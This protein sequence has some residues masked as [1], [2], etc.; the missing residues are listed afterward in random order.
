MTKS[1][2]EELSAFTKKYGAIG[3]AVSINKS[4]AYMTEARVHRLHCRGL[5]QERP[6]L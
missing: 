1:R 6:E 5:R 3:H 4:G 2:A